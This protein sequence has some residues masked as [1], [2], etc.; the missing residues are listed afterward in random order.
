[1]FVNQE[2]KEKHVDNDLLDLYC[3]LSHSKNVILFLLTR[4]CK[5]LEFAYKNSSL[6]FDV[7]YYG[8]QV[9]TFLQ[10]YKKR[11]TLLFYV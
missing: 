7:Q 3:Q 9:M 10:I 4:T 11:Y 5:Y 6:Y 8:I 2:Q 1:M